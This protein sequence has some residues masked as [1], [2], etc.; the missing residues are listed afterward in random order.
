MN[1][2]WWGGFFLKERWSLKHEGINIAR[3]SHCK[4]S[5]FKEWC[6]IYMIDIWLIFY[7][8]S[9]YDTVQIIDQISCSNF[10][11]KFFLVLPVH[12]DHITHLY[13]T[14]ESHCQY[15]HIYRI[16]WPY[17]SLI[18]RSLLSSKKMARLFLQLINW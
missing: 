17:A 13:S 3:L 1:N 11:Q 10:Q 18:T 4:M 9:M 7:N 16:I 8:I 14:E 12:R 15:L 5:L 6:W 2:C